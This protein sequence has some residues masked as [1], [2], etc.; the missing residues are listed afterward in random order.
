[1]EKI[2]R[3]RFIGFS[4]GVVFLVLFVMLLIIVGINYYQVM[5]MHLG[6]MMDDLITN[7]GEITNQNQVGGLPEHN[8][9]P[10]KGSEADKMEPPPINPN[11]EVEMEDHHLLSFVAGQRPI[12]SSEYFR[13]TIN[14]VTKEITADMQ[15]SNYTSES[16]AIIYA[17]EVLK[18]DKDHGFIDEYK[19]AIVKNED[20]IIIYFIDCTTAFNMY[21]NFVWN[22]LWV[23]L[24]A[25]IG[26]SVSIT[27]LSK[28]VVE[29]IARGYEQQNEFIT[30]I[31]HELK[32]P[33]TII[34]GNV[35]V[36]TLQEGPTMWTKSIIDQINRLTKLIDYLIS[37]TKLEEDS[38]L[39]KTTFSL[40][41]LITESCI[42]FEGVARSKHKKIEYT[43][44]P[45]I[46]YMGDT[47]NIELL[48][49]IL[50][51]NALKYSISNSTIYVTLRLI[52]KK[53]T[54][55][56]IN[57]AENLE[58][59]QYN[60]WFERFYRADSSRASK[61][62]GFGIGLSM[63]RAI[64]IRHKGKIT[65]ESLDGKKATLKVVL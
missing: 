50:L 9:L 28:K 44:Q 7:N 38:N 29:V 8:N 39:T 40:S 47:Q 24:S 1:M 20:S 57:N 4:V 30:G 10:F 21:Q 3:R 6:V 60:E 12:Y 18:V 52:N 33:L 15:R 25:F 41:E 63:A 13:V 26:I 35:E 14:E 53:P 59:K 17:R 56:I 43:I 19:Y 32:T 31:S 48:L 23:C 49:S 34:K 22:S 16:T 46:S 58:V 11:I 55:Y 62:S 27:I 37:L 65:A 54:I 42:F 61:T 64:V 5:Y 36:I 2:L 45:D 51:E